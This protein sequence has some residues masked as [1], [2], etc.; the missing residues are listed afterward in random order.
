ME[1]ST[2]EHLHL[3]ALAPLPYSWVFVGSGQPEVVAIVA[4]LAPL[5]AVFQVFDGLLGAAA[6]ARERD[7][8]CVVYRCV[9]RRRE[10]VFV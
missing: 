5:C 10:T 8:V 9:Y 4:N 3:R 6:A 2:F 1:V 7:C